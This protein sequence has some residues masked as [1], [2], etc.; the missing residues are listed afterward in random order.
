MLVE[1]NA[2]AAAVCRANASAVLEGR[3]A[4]AARRPSRCAATAVQTFLTGSGSTYDLVFIDPPYEL[5]DDELLARADG[6]RAA[7]LAARHR[8]RRAQH[9]LRRSRRCRPASTSTGSKEYG[10]TT[11]WWLEPE[12]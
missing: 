1:R 2:Q 6:A 9:P 4:H 7:A 11:L 5:D 3:A 10:D 12:Q 8:L